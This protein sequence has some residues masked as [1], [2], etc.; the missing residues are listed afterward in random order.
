MRHAIENTEKMFLKKELRFIVAVA[1]LI[2][3]WYLVPFIL[4]FIKGVPFSFGP[5]GY[6]FGSHT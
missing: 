2:F 3:L 6:S 4:T 5:V 1:V